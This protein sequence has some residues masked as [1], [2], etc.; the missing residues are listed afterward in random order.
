MA[1]NNG[2]DWANECG[3]GSSQSESQSNTQGTIDYD[4]REKDNEND[5]EDDNDGSNTA[6]AASESQRQ[7]AA[8]RNQQQQQQQQQQQRDNATTRKAVVAA[9]AKMPEARPHKKM[10]P[11]WPRPHS[12]TY[13]NVSPPKKSLRTHLKKFLQPKLPKL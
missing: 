5:M 10:W 2:A 9:N 12:T 8:V 4:T 1:M 13:S 11:P 6:L 3:Y 7:A